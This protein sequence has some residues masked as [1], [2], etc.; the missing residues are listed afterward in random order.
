MSATLYNTASAIHSGHALEAMDVAAASREAT[1]MTDAAPES[2]AFDVAVAI[3]HLQVTHSWKQMESLAAIWNGAIER[4]MIAEDLPSFDR[5]L[6]Y[7]EHNARE[8]AKRKY[9]DPV[10]IFENEI[11]YLDNEGRM[12]MEDFSIDAQQWDGFRI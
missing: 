12:R 3:G 10:A 11:L 7:A 4:G 2:I 6:D 1:K 5:L 9:Y 8:F